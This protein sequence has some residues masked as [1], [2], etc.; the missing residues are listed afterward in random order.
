MMISYERRLEW[1]AMVEEMGSQHGQQLDSER[2]RSFL[3][4]SSADS[5]REAGTPQPETMVRERCNEIHGKTMRWLSMQCGGTR[6]Y[7]RPLKRSTS[8]Q[9]ALSS[10]KR[11]PSARETPSATRRRTG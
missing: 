3:R 7:L 1:A 8:C 9:R 4:L 6:S 5:S 10:P 11:M 2:L